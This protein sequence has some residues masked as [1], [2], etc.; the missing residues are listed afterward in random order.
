MVLTDDTGS[1]LAYTLGPDG[2]NK[3]LERLLG[4][5]IRWADKADLEV[6]T[7]TGPQHALPAHHIAIERGRDARECA[8]RIFVGKVELTFMIPLDEVLAATS[9]LVTMITEDTTH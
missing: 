9:K 3:L 5:A 2:L 6:G 4:L 8:V 1:S 7:L